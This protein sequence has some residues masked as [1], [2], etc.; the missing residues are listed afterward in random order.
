MQ[1]K[2][3]REAAWVSARYKDVL[4]KKIVINFLVYKLV[5]ISL[6]FRKRHRFYNNGLA[7]R[8]VVKR[9]AYSKAFQINSMLKKYG[10]KK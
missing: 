3:A 1:E 5:N 8:Y 2:G 7:L 4:T 10:L 9:N 6:R